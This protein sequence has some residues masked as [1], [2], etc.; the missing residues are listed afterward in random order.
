MVNIG[1]RQRGR[2]QASNI[3]NC[4]NGQSD[5]ARTINQALNESEFREQCAQAVNLYGDGKSAGRICEILRDIPL[6]QKL[7]DKEST[8]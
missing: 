1:T 8:Y 5:I 2:P 6:D 3:L 4:A 7:M